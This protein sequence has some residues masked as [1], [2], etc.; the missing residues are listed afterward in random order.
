MSAEIEAMLARI[1]ERTQNILLNQEVHNKRLNDHAKEIRSLQMWRNFIGGATTVIGGLLG[2][3][4][5]R[6]K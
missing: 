2:F 5:W 6:H 3:E 4:G 1:D